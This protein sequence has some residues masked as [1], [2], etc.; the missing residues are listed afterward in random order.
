M[1]ANSARGTHLVHFGKVRVW[2]SSKK[3]MAKVLAMIE[4]VAS[5]PKFK[6]R[7]V[8]VVQDFPS[9]CGRVTVSNFGLNRQIAVDQSSQGKS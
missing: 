6:W 1:C 7:K 4:R 9:G 5:S 2:G 3:E 8:S